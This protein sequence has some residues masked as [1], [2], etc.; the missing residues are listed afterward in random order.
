MLTSF[1]DLLMFMSIMCLAKV[2]VKALVLRRACG[3]A[4]KFL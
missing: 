1:K 3:P 2:S 4:G